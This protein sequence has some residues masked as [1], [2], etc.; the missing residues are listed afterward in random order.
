MAKIS[1]E[2]LPVMEGMS[3]KDLKGIFGGH[4][5]PFHRRLR[6]GQF[7][8]LERSALANRGGT[9]NSIN[10]A[11]S[12]AAQAGELFFHVYSHSDQTPEW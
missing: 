2:D 4:L 6:R 10:A 9:G 11:A 5:L 12:D 3:E 7:T 1:I 8:G